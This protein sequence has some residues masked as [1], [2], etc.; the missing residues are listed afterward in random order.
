MNFK[1]R[2]VKK[3]V[4]SIACEQQEFRETAAAWNFTVRRNEKSMPRPRLKK[5]VVAQIIERHAHNRA[6]DLK[7]RTEFA[8]RRQRFGTVLP[9]KNHFDDILADQHVGGQV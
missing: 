9:G 4:A 1:K 2:I 8:L 5:S 6:A 3:D 7:T